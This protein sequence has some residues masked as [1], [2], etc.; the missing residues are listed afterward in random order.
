MGYLFV[1]GLG[2]RADSWDKTIAAMGDLEPVS[3]PELFSLL[4]DREY[5]Y[6]GLYQ[7]FEQYCGDQPAPVDL[8]GLSLGAVLALN[9]AAEHPERVRSLVLIAPQFKMPKGLL[10]LQDFLFRFMPER[11]FAEMGTSKCC[12]RGLTNSMEGLD[13]TGQLERIACPVLVLCGEKDK[14]NRKAAEKLSRTLKRA[15]LHFVRRVGHEM[16]VEAPEELAKVLNDFY[17]GQRAVKNG[18]NGDEI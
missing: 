4:K 16:N 8:C 3:C 11:T 13:F 17:C 1:H 18:G 7:G 14:A 6:Q 2:Q 12:F 5:T 10:K 9:Y 15:E